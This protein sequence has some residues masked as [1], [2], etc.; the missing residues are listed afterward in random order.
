MIRQHDAARS[1][2]DRLRPRR[3]M[4]DHDRGRRARDPRHVVVLRQPVAVVAPLF[5]VLCQ[6][7]RIPQRIRCARPL[8][9][10]R[11]IK[12]RKWN[13]QAIRGNHHWMTLPGLGLFQLCEANNKKT[14][15]PPAQAFSGSG[16]LL[17][18]QENY[19]FCTTTFSVELS[20]PVRLTLVGS[21]ASVICHNDLFAVF[22]KLSVT[23]NCPLS[24]SADG[25]LNSWHD[26]WPFCSGT[27]P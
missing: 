26:A 19:C 15:P 10:R 20:T 1:Y 6:I 17:Q 9:Y 2:A 22:V 14:P 24:P 12:N 23:L 21:I 18:A 3:H 27:A 25:E 13:H 4:P 5:C 7:E 8:R 11:Q 16:A